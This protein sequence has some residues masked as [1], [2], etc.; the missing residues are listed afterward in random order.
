MIAAGQGFRLPSSNPQSDYA[1]SGIVRSK[2][3]AL[4]SAGAHA[5]GKAGLRGPVA[6]VYR[7]GRPGR[8]AVRHTG[9]DWIAPLC[10]A[11]DTLS[12]L[13]T[14]VAFGQWVRYWYSEAAR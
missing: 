11:E 14:P 13:A 9:E 12:E 7:Q 2:E 3:C 4:P 6:D 8:F 10:G 1:L 5:V